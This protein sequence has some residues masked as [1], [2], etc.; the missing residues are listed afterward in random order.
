MVPRSPPSGIQVLQE[1]GGRAAADHLV[2]LVYAEL[3][4]L[5]AGYIRAERSGHTLQP[6]ALVH[7]AFVK[8][9]D[10][11]G[12]RWKNRAHFIGV[13]AQLMR[14]ILV[15]HARRRAAAKRGGGNRVTLLDEHAVTR[16]STLD[17]LRVDDALARLACFDPRQSRIVE[18]RFF[19]GLS[20]PETAEALAISPATVKRDWTMAKAW[21]HRE[22]D[23][24][25]I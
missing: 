3:R 10:Q 12:A 18:L 7:E 6:T 5:A 2:P 23:E 19:G 13:A 14:R 20:I 21:L 9:V 8:L 4:R 1:H 22:L 24:G 11:P 15:D 16:T 17:L 25:G